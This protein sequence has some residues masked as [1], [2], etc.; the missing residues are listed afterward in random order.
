MKKVITIILVLLS[1]VV[2][3]G[4]E[5]TDELWLRAVE[6]KMSSTQVYPTQSEYR[7]ITKDKKGKVE[8]E[9]SIFISHTEEDGDIINKFISGSNSRGEIDEDYE[10]V[11]RYLSINVISEEKGI[12]Q[13]TLS[14]KFSLKRESDEKIEG[15]EYAKYKMKM[16]TDKDGK[17]IDS[18]GYVWIDK[19]RGV[20]FKL[21]LDIDPDQKMVKKLQ[22]STYYSLTDE[23]YL[24][25][26]KSETEI[27]V[28]VVIKRIF[29][30][31]IVN[32]SNFK[33][34]EKI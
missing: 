31:Q 33:K 18:E 5:I 20:P 2:L 6:L 1:S 32:R 19:A 25:S 4:Q 24:V 29:M 14:D 28:S 12:F 22:S 3:Y 21:V 10:T 13:T 7:S 23:G 16:K 26:T 8:E 15:I 9:E 17:K 34:L 30:T 27:E 11:Q